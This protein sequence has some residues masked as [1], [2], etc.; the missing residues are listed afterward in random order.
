MAP[1]KEQGLFFVFSCVVFRL[2]MRF[3][4]G[5]RRV[6][7]QSAVLP[8]TGVINRGSCAYKLFLLEFLI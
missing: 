8:S 7:K 1:S 3:L 5:V 2:Q 6:S 4:H